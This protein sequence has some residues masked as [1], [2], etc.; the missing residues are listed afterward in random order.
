M[1]ISGRPFLFQLSPIV[2]KSENYV[3]KWTDIKCFIEMG[4]IEMKNIISYSN[5]ETHLLIKYNGG[6]IEIEAD[7]L[8][9][10]KNYING[11]NYIITR[12]DK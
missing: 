4:S 1:K 6:I 12:K 2:N 3:F 9:D 5:R 10:C 11:F 8:E 7:T